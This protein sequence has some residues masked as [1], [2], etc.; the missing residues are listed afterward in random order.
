M[1][2]SHGLKFRLGCGHYSDDERCD[3][4]GELGPSPDPWLVAG[5]DVNL[6]RQAETRSY[7]QTK[8]RNRS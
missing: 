3:E 1:R 4:C 8:F 5:E 2:D 7:R 6:N